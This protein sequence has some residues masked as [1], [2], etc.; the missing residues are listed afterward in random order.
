MAGIATEAEART[1]SVLV[2]SGNPV[3]F[4]ADLKAASDIARFVQCTSYE[5]LPDLLSR[6]KPEIA[7]T[8]KIGRS[9]FPRQALL[10]CPS[11]KWI[12]AGG[13]GVDHLVP[14]NPDRLVV[15]NS[16]GI[17][18]DIMAQHVLCMM[19]MVNFRI[20]TYLRQQA[21]RVWK[22]YESR[23]LAGQTAGIIGFGSVGRAVGAMAKSQGM[24]VIAVRSRGPGQFDDA[25]EVCGP[26]DMADVASRS[27]FL[28]VCLPLTEQTRGIVDQSVLQAIPKT[29]HLI[30][31]SRGGI[32]DQDALL[33]CLESESFAGAA[34]DVFAQEPLPESSPFWDLENV[35]V[36]PHS[37]SDVFGWEKRVTD[38]FLDNLRRWHEGR[39][40]R[41]VVDPQRG[42]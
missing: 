2:V 8:F 21:D 38:L 5:E 37:S 25:D 10:D 12:H 39:E 40:V 1:H 22:A 27:D 41:N 23:S 13:A 33:R 30:D 26:N 18:G 11:L 35:I 42:Y 20:R 28:V 24:R 9:P 29:S 7:L 32:V 6:E 17:H 36:T 16:S 4:A 3:A 15:T 34:L 14:W 19:L 31:V